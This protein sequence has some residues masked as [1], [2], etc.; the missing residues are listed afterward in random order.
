MVYARNG[1]EALERFKEDPD[2]FVGAVLDLTMPEM[3]GYEV[4]NEISKIKPDMPVIICS[5]FSEYDISKRFSE[6]K[7]AGFIQ[8]PYN[9]LELIKSLK[10]ALEG[11]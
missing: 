1:K 8:K 10:N 6:K 3:D 5:G 9:P 7:P 11:K 4:F 2:K